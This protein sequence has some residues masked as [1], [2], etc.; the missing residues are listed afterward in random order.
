MEAWAL[1]QKRR[2]W[3]ARSLKDRFLVLYTVQ[4]PL[5]VHR[6]S[7]TYLMKKNVFSNQAVEDFIF[8]YNISIIT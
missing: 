1:G 6:V 7:I 4:T 2:T 5:I 8:M 3:F